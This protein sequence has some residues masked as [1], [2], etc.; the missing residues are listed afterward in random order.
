MSWF[1]DLS[2]VWKIRLPV[3]LLGLL[4]AL[5]G[6]SS[7]NSINEGKKNTDTVIDDYIPA[8][9]AILLAQQAISLSQGQ[10]RLFLLEL[11]SYHYETIAQVEKSHQ[12]YFQ[13][14]DKYIDLASA[15]LHQAHFQKLVSEAKLFADIWFTTSNDIFALANQNEMDAAVEASIKQDSAAFLDISEKIDEIKHFVHSEVGRI[16]KQSMA[17][18]DA[19][20]QQQYWYLSSSIF[21][22]LITSYWIPNVISRGIIKL[23]N[24]IQNLKCDLTHQVQINSHDEV[25]KTAKAF[26]LLLKKL[27]KSLSIVTDVG[28]GLAVQVEAIGTNCERNNELTQTQKENVEQVLVIGHKLNNSINEIS[29]SSVDGAKYASEAKN[30]A[31][32]GSQI[33]EE[34]TIQVNAL[35]QTMQDSVQ[36]I[37]QLEQ[38]TADI[39]SVVGVISGIAAQTNLLALNAAIEAARAGDQGRGFAVVADEVRALASR[40]ATS[41]EEIKGIITKIQAGVNKTV[42]TIGL[43]TQ[44]IEV[45]VSKV[46]QA[47]IAFNQISEAVARVAE[48]STTI[49]SSTKEQSLSVGHIYQN[50]QDIN[51]S[52]DVTLENSHYLVSSADRLNQASNELQQALGEFKV[53]RI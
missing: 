35:S 6:W 22:A 8:L 12:V 43:G 2:L 36:V 17:A 18:A 24:S 51:N 32:E 33:I 48:I 44:Q 39:G 27:D 21:V 34:S 13:Q 30:K 49:V 50:M 19:R 38:Q 53:T 45:T 42:S 9:D 15:E 10:E 25:G 31:K 11:A 29:I 14:A 4:I 16:N 52:S 23:K 28:A 47:K 7:L 41:T 40:T 20:I 46:G 5:T 26:N 1:A 37:E 3:L